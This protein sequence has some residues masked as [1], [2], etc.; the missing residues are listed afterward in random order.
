MMNPNT[1]SVAQHLGLAPKMHPGLFFPL[2][3]H[4]AT[5]SL[6]LTSTSFDP[7]FEL[8]DNLRTAKHV[9]D[10]NMTGIETDIDQY[11]AS[12]ESVFGK[13]KVTKHQYTNCGVRHTKHKHGD[14]TMDQHEYIKTLRPIVSHELTG[15][16]PE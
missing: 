6:G 5:S 9:D 11:I 12:V 16:P 2:K 14:V 15:G 3:L 7:E 13:C 10:I 8:K 1:V 4:K